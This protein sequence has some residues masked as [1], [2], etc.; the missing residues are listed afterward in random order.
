VRL[1]QALYE[2]LVAPS[3]QTA[4]A[5]RVYPTIAPEGSALPRITYQRISTTP[6]NSL[7]GHASI[8]L[9]SMQ[10]DC[11]ASTRAA[12]ADLALQVRRAIAGATFKPLV[13]NEYDGF[14]SEPRVY[15][16]TLDLSCWDKGF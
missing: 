14:E 6:Q 13:N 4:A 11:W 8:D 16:H 7:S 10:I 3:P 5:G 9:V 15:R 2:A 12:A 1:E